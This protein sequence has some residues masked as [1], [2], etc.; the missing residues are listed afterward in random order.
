M[1]LKGLRQHQLFVSTDNI[2][3]LRPVDVSTR[4][5]VLIVSQVGPVSAVKHRSDANHAIARP[6]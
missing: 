3:W 5:T 4:P 2:C 1:L 6:A